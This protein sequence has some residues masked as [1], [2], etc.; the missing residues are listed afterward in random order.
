MSIVN[1]DER[2]RTD[3]CRLD[4]YTISSPCEPNGSGELKSRRQNYVCKISKSF[5]SK[6]YSLINDKKTNTVDPDEMAPYE[7]SH[8]DPQCLHIQLLQCLAL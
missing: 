3:G 4:G 2:R 6:L 7:P 8:L 5:Q 1:A